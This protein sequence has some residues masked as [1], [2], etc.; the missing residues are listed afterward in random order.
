MADV[1]SMM[2]GVPVQRMRQ[3]EGLRLRNMATELKQVVVAQDTAIEK[4]VKAIQR[5]RVGLKEQNHPIGAF[6]FLPG[7]ETGG[8]YVWFGRCADPRRYE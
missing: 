6:M 5:N 1:V 4:M 3:S 7:Q 2:T 8:V